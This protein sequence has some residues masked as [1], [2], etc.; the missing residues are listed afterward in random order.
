MKKS[1]GIIVGVIVV[2]LIVIA[3]FVINSNN[4]SAVN[5]NT[6]VI[7]SS[8][9]QVSTS[10]VVDYTLSK[11]V[12]KHVYIDVSDNSF[13]PQAVTIKAGT[14]VT[15]INNDNVVHKILSDNGGPSSNNLSN[16]QSY[17]FVYRVLGIYGYHDSIYPSMTGTI[18]VK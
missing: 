2:V 8:T 12:T 1:T 9:V 17:S 3:Y 15:W 7:S 13:N 4:N 10:N 11:T 14:T 16:G 6:N 5:S 18:I